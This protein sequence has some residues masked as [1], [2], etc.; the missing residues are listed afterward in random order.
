MNQP[1][2]NCEIRGPKERTLAQIEAKP[3]CKSSL[4]GMRDRAKSFVSAQ[5]IE[6]NVLQVNADSATEEDKDAHCFEILLVS[7]YSDVT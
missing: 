5:S 6:V 4:S 1:K 3:K 7:F 2:T